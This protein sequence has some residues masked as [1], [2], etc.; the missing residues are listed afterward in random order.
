MVFRGPLLAEV[1]SKQ[2]G[3]LVHELRSCGPLW[4]EYAIKSDSQSLA[5]L[6]YRWVI[7]LRRGAIPKAIQ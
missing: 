3:V 7:C 5:F 4:A 6:S 2:F 1:W